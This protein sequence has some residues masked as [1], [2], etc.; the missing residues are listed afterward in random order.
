MT[1]AVVELR[2]PRTCVS[3]EIWEREVRLIMR[4]HDMDRNL[5][6]RTF[7]QTVAYLVT[8]AHNPMIAMGPAQAVDKGLHSFLLD[9]P[10]YWEFCLRHAGRYLHHV[11]HLP[12]ERSSQPQVLRQTIEAI[13]AAGFALDTELWGTR[14]VE[15]TQCY[16]GCS[17]SPGG[18]K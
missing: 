11:P 1:A 13:R 16:A 10:N 18:K 8:A 6:E 2:D 7:G 9:T 17:D 15:C 4:D 5:A 3:P 12:E 14:E